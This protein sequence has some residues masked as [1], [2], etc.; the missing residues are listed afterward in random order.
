M[1]ATKLLPHKD[2]YFHFWFI[3]YLIYY[4]AYGNM[5]SMT[6]KE[7]KEWRKQYGLTQVELSKLLGVTRSTVARWEIGI[8]PI[9]PYLHLALTTIANNL[10]KEGGEKKHGMR[11]KKTR[12]VGN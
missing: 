1:P 8:R 6:G 4:I 10:Q 12:K 5:Y 11:K 3:F 2:K 9:S 7:L